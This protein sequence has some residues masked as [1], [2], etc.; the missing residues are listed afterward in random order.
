[1]GTITT[2]DAMRR[3]HQLRLVL[4]QKG[5]VLSGT[6]H[7][8]SSIDAQAKNL[9]KRDYFALASWMRLTKKV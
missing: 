8:Q 6:I 2:G 5:G 9:P 1:M 7:A 4:R 3:P